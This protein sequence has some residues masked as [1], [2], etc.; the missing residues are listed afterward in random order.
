MNLARALRIFLWSYVFLYAVFSSLSITQVDLWWQLA[1]GQHILQTG[2][3]PTQPVAA[4]GLPAAPYFDEYAG[5]EVVLALLYHAAG[6]AGLWMAFAAVFLVILFL[7]GATTG[8]KYPSFDLASIFALAAAILL[9]HP[10]LEQRPELVGVLF[11]V[12]LMVLLRASSLEK[13]TARL[14]IGLPVLFVAWSNTHSTFLFG[15]LT[16]GLWIANE[17]WRLFK[18]MPRG[19]LLRRSGML[20]LLAL[21]ASIITPY[22]PRRLLFPFL[23]ASDFGSTAL[24]PEM[25]PITTCSPIALYIA[26]TGVTF[27]AWGILTTRRLPLWLIAFSIFSVVISCKSFR[28][29]DFAAV[30]ILF[31]Y[32]ARIEQYAER[33]RKF[34]L[35][36]ALCRDLFLVM[37]C[38]LFLFMDAFN[39]L[40]TYS[41]LRAELR[42]PTHGLRYASDMAAYPVEP[43]DHR[44]PVLCG[45]GMG[46]YLSFK[47]NGNF[48]PLLDSGLSHFSDDTKRYFFFLWN[49]P[50]ALDLALKHLHVEY[51]LLNT[52]TAPWIPTIAR[53]PDWQFVT[54][55]A[56]GMIWK[57]SPGGPHPLSDA[58]RALIANTMS[59][60]L[61]KDDPVGAF[62]LST[63][64]EPPATS[65]AYLVHPNSLPWIDI[66][67]NSFSDW[68]DHLPPGDVE[69]LLSS[70]TCSQHPILGAIL[71]ARLGPQAYDRFVAAHPDHSGKWY[72]K[73]L[74]ARMLLAEGN[75][76]EARQVFE[77]ISPVPPASTFYYHVWHEVYAVSSQSVEL[78]PYGQWQTWDENEIPFMETM[79]QRLNERLAKLAPLP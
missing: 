38:I 3:L 24:S 57:R 33:A 11:Q 4:F 19:L 21:A 60:Q 13:I 18:I 22:G 70:D 47:E 77:S 42:F 8:R 66:F 71:A 75:A 55:S 78:G 15:F 27:L 35:V 44:I 43:E 29:I 51:I 63:L 31:V 50:E 45:H 28:F 67:F 62:Y 76:E 34:P 69:S 2:T 56:N 16:L 36:L 48:R 64:I 25:W 59:R 14:V 1:E 49:E 37:F 41:D 26:V 12:L 20:G 65:L 68:T 74:A 54:C 73:A 53:S 61:Q 52:E 39:I 58:D 23:E 7:P 30:S 46:A 6:F 5:Y 72:G 9:I 79:S 17:W 40:A 32:A 10:R